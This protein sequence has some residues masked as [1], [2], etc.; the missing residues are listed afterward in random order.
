MAAAGLAIPTF[1]EDTE[2]ESFLERLACYYTVAGS[3]FY[4]SYV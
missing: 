3:L 1:E 2:V 4:C